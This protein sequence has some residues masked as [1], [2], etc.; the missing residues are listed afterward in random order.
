MTA[1]R[2][3]RRVLVLDDE[4][5]N[6]GLT[7]ETFS[8][9]DIEVLTARDPEQ[10][11][12]TLSAAGADVFV[13]DAQISDVDFLAA[14]REQAPDLPI[15]VM[16]GHSDGHLVTDT[17]LGTIA[18]TILSEPLK[19]E[20]IVLAVR[21]TFLRRA[22]ASGA[23]AASI[24]CNTKRPR[25]VLAED[26]GACRLLLSAVLSKQ[27]YDVTCT[28]DGAAALAAIASDDF[29][30][31]ITD[32]MMPRLDGLQLTC[33]IKKLKPGLPIIVL[34][35]ASDVE[36]SLDALY[37]GAYCYINKP[38]NHKELL[39]V[40]ERAIL[41][42][43]LQTELREQNSLLEKRA[44]EMN[45]LLEELGQ[46]SDLYAASRLSTLK[47]VSG[48]VAHEL[49]NPLNSI[50]ASFCYVR[51]R[52]PKDAFATNPKIGKHCDIIEAQIQR[53]Q[54]IIDSI[55]DFATPDSSM[56]EGVRVND[57]LQKAIALAFPGEAPIAVRSEL[58]Q[59]LPPVK[60]SER[61]LEGVFVNLITNAAK[62]MKNDGVLTITT[63]TNSDAN[64]RIVFTDTGP[65]VPT[66]I[67]HKVFDPFFTT[68]QR[69]DNGLGLAICKESVTK[70]GG[71]IFVANGPGGGAVFTV[72]LPQSQPAGVAA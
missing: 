57:V 50:N 54:S 45:G 37:A 62:A 34:S 51:S 5:R 43:R 61:A 67:I 38:V 36:T 7:P 35:A 58:D 59:A 52:I 8:S 12:E 65:G 68:N 27:G 22:L 48:N 71:T 69:Q 17:Q 44:E 28:E 9:A 15:I 53:S 31:L 70:C 30:L 4:K 33:E 24:A 72:T 66:S 1:S 49:K 39:L 2:R 23:E 20:D 40:V 16:V 26:D 41:T 14:V 32:I 25:V 42:D 56:E 11:R 47:K 63:Q 18:T 55:L 3:G 46:Q 10:A 6:R 13:T 19:Q 60:A 29:D 64:V 21:H